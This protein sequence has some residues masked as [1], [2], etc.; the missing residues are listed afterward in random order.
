MKQIVYS[1]W[2]K[3]NQHLSNVPAKFYKPNGRR[4]R[5]GWAHCCL[6]YTTLIY[7]NFIFLLTYALIT[8]STNKPLHCSTSILPT[9]LPYHSPTYS[10]LIPL[11]L[12]TNLNSFFY[13]LNDSY[14]TM[15]TWHSL[16]SLTG[17]RQRLPALAPVPVHWVWPCCAGS[18]LH[19][20]VRWW[21]LP[22][23]MSLG[24]KWCSL[25]SHPQCA[26]SP[27]QTRRLFRA[28]LRDGFRWQY[29]S[30]HR[31]ITNRKRCNCAHCKQRDFR[32]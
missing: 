16:Q 28:V 32:G 9:L 4:S 23:G 2:H 14:S 30:L 8:I 24:W 19:S 15:L 6:D 7:L 18:P 12:F 25:R 22:Q 10:Y 1:L 11:L 29:I 21:R 5:Y 3:T 17:Q 20:W 27:L 13:P 31:S 26:P